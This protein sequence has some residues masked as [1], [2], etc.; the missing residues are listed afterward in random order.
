M[1]CGKH[2][3]TS[4]I[5]VGVT[6]M[7]YFLLS[8]SFLGGFLGVLAG[9]GVPVSWG[10]DCS[11]QVVGV[12][13]SFSCGAQD[14]WLAVNGPDASVVTP[15][16][17]DLAQ[18]LPAA[19]ISALSFSAATDLAN[20]HAGIVQGSTLNRFVAPVV[21]PGLTYDPG[22]FLASGNG[23]ITLSLA[24]PRS[25]IGF[26]WGS[27]DPWNTLRLYSNNALIGTLSG[28]A[29]VLATQDNQAERHSYFM[30]I[31]ALGGARFDRVEF[32]SVNQYAFEVTKLTFD[33]GVP[34]PPDVTPEDVAEPVSLAV[35]G[36]GLA[37]LWAARRRVA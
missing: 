28:P 37:G 25:Y 19:W 6:V 33:A 26:T 32:E 13:A 31:R 9:G 5:R 24:A 12:G 2:L 30:N 15:V 14:N 16:A 23:V 36:F 17:I 4:P 20:G 1:G 3:F 11:A 21:G 18:P 22:R 8:T 34:R 7:R 29:L 35:L 27:L 10:A